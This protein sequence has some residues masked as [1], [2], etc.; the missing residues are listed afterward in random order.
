MEATPS[1]Q[2]MDSVRITECSQE[3][4]TPFGEKNA[5]LNKCTAIPGRYLNHFSP[6]RG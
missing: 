5:K 6:F 4:Q 2:E 3:K 1:G